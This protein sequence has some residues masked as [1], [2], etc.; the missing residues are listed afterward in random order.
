MRPRGPLLLLV[1]L[2][3]IFHAPPAAGQLP[4][5]LPRGVSARLLN[6]TLRG[7]TS[8]CLFSPSPAGPRDTHAFITTQRGELFLH[9]GAAGSTRPFAD[10]RGRRRIDETNEMGL[11][12]C[13]V[14]GSNVILFYSVP[15]AH[16]VSRVPFTLAPPVLQ[17]WRERVLLR[18]PRTDTARH[19]GGSLAWQTIGGRRMLLIGRGE[20]AACDYRQAGCNLT[21]S[22]NDYRG[23][24]LRIDPAT[25]AGVPANPFYSARGPNSPASRIFLMGVRNP[26]GIAPLP[27]FPA[28]VAVFDP[29]DTRRES[30]RLL[31][32]GEFGGWP[33]FEGTLPYL[34]GMCSPALLRAR[35]TRTV[36]YPH[37]NEDSCIAGGVFVPASWRASL[38]GRM[39]FADYGSGV[40]RTAGISATGSAGPMT[41]FARGAYGVVRV[42]SGVLGRVWLMS[43]SASG[44]VELADTQPGAG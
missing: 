27:A 15:G 31:G 25:G 22:T 9:D 28:R 30:I 23:K 13:A 8:A 24:I 37:R 10:L 2:L 3:P 6:A 20:D 26:W 36:D 1:C 35:S 42:S 19:A 18:M 33:C 44:I 43:F 12:S 14:D 7:P 38:G 40:L 41:V 32:K 4:A 39:L 11:L 16:I 34:Q 29:G 21:L 5:G 17:L